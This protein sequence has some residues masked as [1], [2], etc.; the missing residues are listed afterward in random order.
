[1]SNNLFTQDFSYAGTYSYGTHPDSGATGILHVYQTSSKNLIFHLELNRG[2]PS[3]NSGELVGEIKIYSI[4]EGDFTIKKD[5]DFIN[6]SMN[7]WFHNDSVYIRTNNRAD[8]CGYGYGVYSY[9]DFKR[10]S[11]ENPE[12]FIN[13]SG[14]T[15]YFKNL[16]WKEW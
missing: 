12:Y 15:I 3:Y 1:L 16:D 13:R 8:N 9:G 7:L 10:I 5:S 2:A 6:C 14:K 4:G 11:F